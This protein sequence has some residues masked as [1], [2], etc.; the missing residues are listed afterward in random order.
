MWITR[1]SILFNIYYACT[2]YYRSIQ[3]EFRF[4]VKATLTV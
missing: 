4:M 2:K 1:N 3:E